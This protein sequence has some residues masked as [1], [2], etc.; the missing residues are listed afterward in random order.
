MRPAATFAVLLAMCSALAACGG[1]DWDD[2]GLCPEPPVVADGRK[3]IPPEP[4][5]E[6]AL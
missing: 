3:T 4:C 5:K 6:A 1:G 2:E